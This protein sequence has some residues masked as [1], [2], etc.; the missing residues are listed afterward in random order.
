[1]STADWNWPPPPGRPV[2][3]SR[4]FFSPQVSDSKELLRPQ[5]LF[6][7]ELL[8]IFQRRSG[9]Q[10]PAELSLN[11]INKKNDILFC[12]PFPRWIRRIKP[13][14]TFTFLFLLSSWDAKYLRVSSS[15]Y[16]LSAHLHFS[17]L[18]THRRRERA[19]LH[20]GCHRAL[21]VQY[22][23]MGFPFLKAPQRNVRPGKQKKRSAGA[24]LWTP[25]L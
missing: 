23:F 6:F 14:Q 24:K 3:L 8:I 19:R 17:A 7:V 16:F 5:L 22:L 15:L 13:N 1:M 21:K 9:L 4:R 12:A 11:T 2:I 18:G 20:H 10:E 25:S